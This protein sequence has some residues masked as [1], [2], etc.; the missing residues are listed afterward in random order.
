M[1]F[2]ESSMEPHWLESQDLITRHEKGRL[3]SLTSHPAQQLSR[4][5]KGERTIEE[6]VNTLGLQDQDKGMTGPGH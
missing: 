3:A 5:R 2:R 4:L 1:Q 6:K